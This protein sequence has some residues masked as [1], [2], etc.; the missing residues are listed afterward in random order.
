MVKN[1][2]LKKVILT[3]TTK[4]EVDEPISPK[5]IVK[6]G[7][8]TQEEWDYVSEKA[9]KL[10]KYG[11]LLAEKQG[12]IL[13][14]TKYEF[15]KTA[16]GQI[17]LIDELHTCDS[18]RYWIR[19]SYRQRFTAGE[20]PERL[21]KDIIRMYLKE[22]MK[23]PYEGKIPEIPQELK[24]ELLNCY[25]GFYEKLTGLSPEL[26]EEQPPKLLTDIFF[27]YG[28]PQKAIILSGS[29]SDGTHVQ[30]LQEQLSLRQIYSESYVASAH[31]T[32]R[33][34]LE[35]LEQYAGQ[36]VIWITVAGM[37]NAL[38]GVVAGNTTQPVIACPPFSSKEDMMVNIHST[39]QCPSNVPVLTV[40]KPGNVALCCKRIFSS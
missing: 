31:K 13:V 1:Q 21:D 35:I 19:K 22:V 27:R 40:L 32:T 8:M 9:L 39:L 30:K 15:G 2:R 20:E 36:N 12:F 24:D 18:S 14:D 34:L 7:L 3:P 10:F 5:E 23:N 4:G 6:R 37:S 16:D 25:R 33:R 28:I 38:S 26:E 29:P 11:Q 17:L